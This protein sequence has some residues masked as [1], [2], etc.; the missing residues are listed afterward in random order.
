MS[1]TGLGLGAAICLLVVSCET[2]SLIAKYNRFSGDAYPLDAYDRSVDVEAGAD[3]P[4]L[5][6][7]LVRG[8]SVSFVPAVEVIEPF[9]ER[10]QRFE[11]IVVEVSMRH[12]GRKPTKIVNAGGYYCRAVRHRPE[13]LSEHAL[14]NAIDVVGFE[15]PP[16][17]A[18]L[19][20]DVP[21][22][23]EPLRSG[24]SV[25]IAEH[26]HA[27]DGVAAMHA[28]FLA[29]VGREL[30]REGVFRRMLGPSHPTHGTHFHFDMAPYEY[31]RL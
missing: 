14:G 4:D 20:A 6:L 29:A 22:L 13:R 7:E 17:V 16:A 26:W 10:L 12:Y 9:A 3:C 31:V 11:D 5:S 8:K 21:D 28:E 15:F 27:A 18:G 2:S 25:R 23:P 30:E 1:R 24:F 19:D